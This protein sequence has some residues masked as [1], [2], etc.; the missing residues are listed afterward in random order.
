MEEISSDA[1]KVLALSHGN[2]RGNPL[3]DVNRLK[4]RRNDSA[5]MSG[6]KSRRTALAST[7]TARPCVVQVQSDPSHIVSSEI[8]SCVGKWNNQSDSERGESRSRWSFVRMASSLAAYYT[9]MYELLY[10]LS[11][12]YKP[13]FRP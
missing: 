1:L 11:S 2:L 5:V 6:T 8:Q 9:G 4:Q 7:G 12:L 10:D 3:L 13:V